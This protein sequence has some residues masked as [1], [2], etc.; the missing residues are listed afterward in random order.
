M[1][2]I[3]HILITS[4]CYIISMS[5]ALAVEIPEEMKASMAN[6]AIATPDALHLVV[7]MILVIG[8]I[9]FT[10]WIYSKL[11]ILNRNKLKKLSK[12]DL[13]KH[14]FTVLQSMPLGQQRNIYSIEMGGKVLL[15][16]ATQ[17]QINLLKEFDSEEDI[18]E[19]EENILEWKEPENTKSTKNINIDELYKKY[20][21]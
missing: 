20:K 2:N 5:N 10:G 14:H 11:N 19:K 8:M 12:S 1:N 9:Y 15:I 18:P 16:G 4:F 3:K 21:N 17:S 7:S 6:R 13:N